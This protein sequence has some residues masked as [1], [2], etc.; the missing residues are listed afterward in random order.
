M[1]HWRLRNSACNPHGRSVNIGEAKGQGR[2]MG[3]GNVA[4]SPIM[5]RLWFEAA[6]TVLAIQRSVYKQNERAEMQIAVYIFLGAALAVL[7]FIIAIW[8]LFRVVFPWWIKRH[9]ARA[10]GL[11]PAPLNARIVPEPG[12]ES[13][14]KPQS[15]EQIREFAA[16]GFQEIGRATVYEM[17]EVHLWLGLASDGSLAIVT[18]P[19]GSLPSS[20]DVLRVYADYSTDCAS[21]SSVH[22]PVNTPEGNVHTNQYP[23]SVAAAAAAL[24]AMPDRSAERGERLAITADNALHTVARLYARSMD[25]ILARPPLQMAEFR[26]QVERINRVEDAKAPTPQPRDDQEWEAALEMTRASRRSAL[27]EALLDNFLESG[28]VSAANWRR[29][30]DH[31]TLIHAH[32]SAQEAFE[33]GAGCV[34]LDPSEPQMAAAMQRAETQIPQMA[35][36]LAQASTPESRR[37]VAV[38]QVSKPVQA[39]WFVP[40]H[41][42]KQVGK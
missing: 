21:A 19:P 22:N 39:V 1:Q 30:E 10:M 36:E 34:E 14:H 6:R 12:V 5:L 13:W 24:R 27:E 18:D 41:V 26:A 20:F 8:L 15:E 28:V 4:H 33:L 40:S 9:A 17:S 11:A 25:T 23:W 35:F 2:L 29:I 42:A 7:L 3:F 31:A 32:M 37:W 16:L 38:A